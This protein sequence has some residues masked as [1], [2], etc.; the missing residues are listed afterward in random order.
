MMN[1]GDIMSTLGNVQYTR[2]HHEY[3]GRCS[4][5]WGIIKQGCH[6]KSFYCGTF[7]NFQFTGP[8]VYNV[9]AEHKRCAGHQGMFSTMVDIMC[10]LGG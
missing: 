1:V 5:H 8:K 2:G 9:C 6:E 4:V 10:I 3:T 7:R